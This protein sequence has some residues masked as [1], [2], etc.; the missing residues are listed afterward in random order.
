MTFLPQRKRTSLIRVFASNIGLGAIVALLVVGC[1]TSTQP[2]PARPEII[3]PPTRSAIEDSDLRALL[4]D[5][6]QAQLCGALEGSFSGLPD[7]EEEEGTKTGAGA[8]GGRLWIRECEVEQQGDQLAIDIGGPGWVWMDQG[9]SGFEVRDYLRLSAQLELRGELDL[10]YDREK[11]IVSIWFTPRQRV[12]SK[13]AAI[14]EVP[15]QPESVLAKMASVLSAVRES[16]QKQAQEAVIEDG[17]R[18]FE[19]ALQSGFTLTANLCDGQIDSMV[20]S[21]GDGETPARP[22]DPDGILWLANERVRLRQGGIDIAGPWNTKGE[23]LRIEVELERGAGLEVRALCETDAGR[24]ADAFLHDR[25]EPTLNAHAY[26]TLEQGT[27]TELIVENAE[28]PIALI[29]R[30]NGETDEALQF[31]F[32][33]HLRGARSESLVDCS[34]PTTPSESTPNETLPPS[35]SPSE[36]ASQP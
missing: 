21:L 12:T 27:T 18:L 17:S 4:R 11:H 28:C 22:Y 33:A 2:P 9:A 24:V 23:P 6:A 15:V 25:E 16:A 13:V 31:R 10:G 5:F 36:P 26:A 19:D 7:S 30:V 14:G 29:S 8:S 1:A 35:A 32:R 3:P 20:G 34:E